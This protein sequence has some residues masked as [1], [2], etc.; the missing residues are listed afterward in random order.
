[1]NYSLDEILKT[2]YHET[3]YGLIIAKPNGD[4]Y[5]SMHNGA[6]SRIKKGT[7]KV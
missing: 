5:V 2:T 4:I 6:I 1:M 7:G 3:A